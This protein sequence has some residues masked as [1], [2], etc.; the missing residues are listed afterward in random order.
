MSVG[1]NI[2]MLDRMLQRRIWRVLIGYPSVAF[3]LLQ[4]VEFFIN[5]YGLDPRFLTG[6]II[7]AAVLMP[8]AFLWN[9]RHGEVGAQP[10]IHSE[11]AAYALSIVAAAFAVFLYWGAAPAAGPARTGQLASVAPAGRS[12]AV[13]P[14]ENPTGDP[15]VQYLC[16]GIAEG[17]I[18]WLAT[19]PEIRVASKRASFRLRDAGLDT[20]ALADALGVDSLVQG[21]L[22]RV[23]DQLI[24]SVSL[25]NAGDES[26][27]WGERLIETADEVLYLEQSILA[28]LQN[29]LRVE[30]TED[31]LE[32]TGGTNSPSAYEHYLRGHH[33]I[34]ATDSETVN[35]G[36]EELRTAIR[37]DPGYARA[38]ADLADALS[39]LL[40]Y[41]LQLDEQLI[42]EARTAAQSAVALAPRLPEAYTALARMLE[43]H[44]GD[45][46]AIE[47]AYETAISLG[48]QTPVPYHRYTDHL[49]F[50]QRPERA[51]EMARQAIAMDPLDGSSMHAVG[52]VELFS[53]NFAEAAVAFGEWNRFHPES[54]WSWLKH[55]LALALDGQCEQSQRQVD[56]F[57]ER[58]GSELSTLM[59]SWVV[60]ARKACGDPDWRADAQRYIDRELAAAPV[61][62]NAGLAYLLA[63][64]GDTDTL[65]ELCW[66][67]YEQNNPLTLNVGIF[68][69]QG[70]GWDI[71]DSVARDPRFVALMERI[72]H[73][74]R[75]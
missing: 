73:P 11:I 7:V 28:A 70:M 71:E 18:N 64:V 27:V 65:I 8:A 62:L 54:R 53:G 39:Q 29:G 58:Y 69:L 51:R 35:Q 38:Y 44:E 50:T 19:V 63:L 12:I 48:P 42:G 57:K 23:G 41:G 14:F 67:A 49:I 2:S 21:R 32:V 34:Q 61:Q 5:N 74:V 46:G 16:D 43:L 60:W 37:I 36:I 20:R 4:V 45:W 47:Q 3:V 40:S 13:M 26:Q 55:A 17:L 56:G 6:G 33:L 59:F 66:Q 25:I 9:W 15:E 1:S 24:V 52:I 30:V 75:D 22:E 10:F 68:R 72:D 31:A